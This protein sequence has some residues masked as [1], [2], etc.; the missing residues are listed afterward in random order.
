MKPSLKSLR[1]N[2]IEG[3]RMAAFYLPAHYYGWRDRRHF[4]ELETYCLFLGYPRSGHSIVGS[5]LDAHPEIV[6]AQELAALKYLWAGFS[7]RQLYHLLLRN[8]RRHA[9]K[10]RS[11]K[12]YSYVVPGQWQGRCRRLRVIGDK[13]G[14]G[15]VWTLQVLPDLLERLYQTVSLDI[16]FIHVTRNPFDNISTISR[17]HRLSLEQSIDYYFS[18]CETIA[19]LKTRIPTGSLIDIRHE[20]FVADPW[21]RMSELCGFLGVEASGEYL[22]DCSGIVNAKPNRSRSRCDWSRTAIAEVEARAGRF[23][24][25][26]GYSYAGE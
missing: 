5:L 16:R 13:K 18:L 15:S 22:H 25:L 8:S 3:S 23:S 1:T 19:R 9:Q 26:E 14:G 24:F 21:A 4:D 11:S 20:D 2:L 12:E 6:V 17:R 7:A 10:G